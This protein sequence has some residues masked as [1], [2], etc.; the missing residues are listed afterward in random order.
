MW[1]LPWLL[2]SR[3]PLSL[4]LFFQLIANFQVDFCQPG[5]MGYALGRYARVNRLCYKDV[6]ILE[7]NN[8]CSH[9]FSGSKPVG[10]VGFIHFLFKRP[11]LSRSWELSMRKCTWFSPFRVVAWQS[12]FKPPH[13]LMPLNAGGGRKQ[14]LSH[15]AT[16]HLVLLA[17]QK[18]CYILV[19]R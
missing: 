9:S 11:R 1:P 15:N 8:K 18:D 3:P 13:C 19:T 2:N 14:K 16:A 7:E 10:Q 6:L 17:F 4:F 12:I 5:L